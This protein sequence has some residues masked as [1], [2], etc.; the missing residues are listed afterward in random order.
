MAVSDWVFV[1]G[2][3]VGF[4]TLFRLIGPLEPGAAIPDEIPAGYLS[5]GVTVWPLRGLT[6]LIGRGSNADID[7]RDPRVSWVHAELRIVAGSVLL[8]D[9]DARYCT[10]VNDRPLDRAVAL[11]DG[12]VVT[13]GRTE[14]T[15][16]AAAQVDAWLSVGGSVYPLRKQLLIGRGSDNDVEVLDRAASWSHAELRREAGRVIVRDLWSSHGTFLNGVR[17]E[18]WA[19]LHD[20]DELKIGSTVMSYHG[21]HAMAQLDA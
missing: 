9:L 21:L 1:V 6:L 4:L 18:R 7:L 11:V 19:P 8:R 20:G 17:V 2:G 3:V 10:R 13:V 16:H 14:L 5:D 15:F 12:D